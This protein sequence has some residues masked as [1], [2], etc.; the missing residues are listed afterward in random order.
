MFLFACSVAQLRWEFRSEVTPGNL[1][2]YLHGVE[3]LNQA[4]KVG[5]CEDLPFVVLESES[6]QD[7]KSQF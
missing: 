2:D 1:S 6:A 4:T 7:R 5:C 3:S